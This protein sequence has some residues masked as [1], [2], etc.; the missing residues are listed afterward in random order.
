MNV[1]TTPGANN[2]ASTPGGYSPKYV[3][4]QP[5]K[6]LSEGAAP[7]NDT[8]ENKLQS[9]VTV[10]RIICPNDLA[11]MARLRCCP[12][13]SSFG[14]LSAHMNP[15][16]GGIPIGESGSTVGIAALWRLPD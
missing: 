3:P 16:A 5:D 7:A 11:S 9:A 1:E 12:L 14:L 6:V 13:L 10:V 15:G 4:W 8:T 2:L